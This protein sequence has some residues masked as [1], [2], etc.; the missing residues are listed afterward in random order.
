M[1]GIGSLGEPVDPNVLKRWL[2]MMDQ[3]QDTTANPDQEERRRRL[4]Q[5][6]ADRR[7]EQARV[8][9]LRPDTLMGDDRA[10][11]MRHLNTLGDT[12]GF[13]QQGIQ[14]WFQSGEIEE[15]AEL[16]RQIRA[17][18][19]A[20]DP[21]GERA[22]GGVGAFGSTDDGYP[23]VASYGDPGSNTAAGYEILLDNILL[24]IPPAF[25]PEY[26]RGNRE[27]HNLRGP[28]FTEE[29]WKQKAEDDLRR[30]YGHE[31]GHA[32]NHYSADRG[33]GFNTEERAADNFSAVLE[34][35]RNA[36]PE[37]S[38]KDVLKEADRLL[39]DY[40]SGYLRESIQKDDGFSGSSGE[41]SDPLVVSPD[42]K[43]TREYMWG[44]G[45]RHLMGKI[46]DTEQFA[47]HPLNR[48][49]FERL[50]DKAQRGIASLIRR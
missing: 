18:N 49:L 38:E 6:M 8:V 16:V 19:K 42:A 27:S 43:K 46:L 14:D 9:S 39:Y 2:A 41:F 10:D 37:D 7:A 5:L 47:D 23:S 44:G 29:G 4:L 45:T 28:S 35:L 17:M 48:T 32:A 13:S 3:Q 12:T 31:L 15:G 36:G 20:R 30:R 11:M 50:R 25:S 22:T 33:F 34:A 24:N 26:A 1:E 21:E 40:P